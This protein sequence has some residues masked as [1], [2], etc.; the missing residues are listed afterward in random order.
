MTSN[1]RRLLGALCWTCASVAFA[2][3]AFSRFERLRAADDA[4]RRYRSTLSHL[5]SSIG[6]INDLEIRLAELEAAKSRL[7]G[8]ASSGAAADAAFAVR[9]ALGRQN[10][11]PERYQIAGKNGDETVEF[12]FESRPL[13]ALRFLERFSADCPHLAVMSLT[14]KPD[15]RSGTVK[16]F[17]RIAP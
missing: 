2:F 17:M 8:T 7:S 15:L 6:A 3:F 13:P 11:I 1:E 9:A 5:D 4:E 16:F 12:S 10:I 14:A